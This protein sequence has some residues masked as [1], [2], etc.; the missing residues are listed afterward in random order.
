[1]HNRDLDGPGAD[2]SKKVAQKNGDERESTSPRL[3]VTPESRLKY[4]SGFCMCVRFMGC[5]LFVLLSV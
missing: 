1:M 2:Q 3:K 5:H 4:N